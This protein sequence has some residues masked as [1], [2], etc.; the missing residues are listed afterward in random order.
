[1]TANRYR[2]EKEDGRYYLYIIES[3]YNEDCM[4]GLDSPNLLSSHNTIFECEQRIEEYE[5]NP[6]FEGTLEELNDADLF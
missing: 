1:M 5:A 3:V 2:I 6:V 4:E